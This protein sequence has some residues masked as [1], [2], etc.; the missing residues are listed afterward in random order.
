M[1]KIFN[2]IFGGKA[3]SGFTIPEYVQNDALTVEMI[4]GKDAPWHEIVEFSLTFDG[5]SRTGAFN[6][7]AEVAY[8]RDCTTLSEMRACLFFEQKQLL[9]LKEL[10]DS[11]TLAFIYNL[12]DKISEKIKRQELD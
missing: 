12:L 8:S 10:P 1:R 5:Y 4:P 7:C 11:E 2:R 6:R 3:Q 9:C